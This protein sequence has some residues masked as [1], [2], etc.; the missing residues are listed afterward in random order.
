MIRVESRKCF[1][2]RVYFWYT[3]QSLQLVH[4]SNKR[5]FVPLF[6]SSKLE[7]SSLQPAASYCPFQESVL[8]RSGERYAKDSKLINSLNKHGSFLSAGLPTIGRCLV[9]IFRSQLIK[10]QL[11]SFVIEKYRYTATNDT[12]RSSLILLLQVIV[13]CVMILTYTLKR[14]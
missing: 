3:Y 13:F 12:Y 8:D 5:M 11:L 2:T 10:Q 6:F 1:N 7:T 9:H 4:I 14:R